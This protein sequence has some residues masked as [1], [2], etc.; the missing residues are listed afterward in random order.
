[1]RWRR[2]DDGATTESGLGRTDHGR[3]IAVHRRQRRRD[4]P[5]HRRTPCPGHDTSPAPTDAAAAGPSWLQ[6]T[7]PPH[8]HQGCCLSD[9]STTTVAALPNRTLVDRLSSRLSYLSIC[10]DALCF[11]T[12]AL[13]IM[14]KYGM[15][16]RQGQTQ[17]VR[18]RGRHPSIA[19]T[20]PPTTS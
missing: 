3:Y 15:G 17:G 7:L 5:G 6:P 11:R 13:G 20:T 2:D 1:M 12:T 10:E 16:R 8:Q 19:R 9:A 18:E 14:E 4:G